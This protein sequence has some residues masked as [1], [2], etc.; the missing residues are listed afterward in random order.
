[1]TDIKLWKIILAGEKLIF[2]Q[3][4]ARVASK[5]EFGAGE[6]REVSCEAQ[7]G[8]SRV[9]RKLFGSCRNNMGDVRTL[10]MKEAHA[11]KYSVRPG[12]NEVVARHGVNVSTIPDRDG[13][14][15][16]VSERD[17]EVVRNT[18]RYEY[19]LPSINWWSDCYVGNRTLV[20]VSKVIS[21][22]IPIVKVSWNS[23]RNFELTWAWEDYLKDK[24]R[25]N[26]D[27]AWLGLTNEEKRWW[28]TNWWPSMRKDIAGR[29]NEAVAR[30]GVHVSTIP[31]R[32]GMY[33]KV[34][35]KDVE[36]VRNT[37]RYEYYLPSIN[38]WSE[39]FARIIEEFGFALRRDSCVDSKISFYL[40]FTDILDTYWYFR[41]GLVLY[42]FRS[43]VRLAYFV[44]SKGALDLCSLVI[45][46]VYKKVKGGA[47]VAFKDE[48]KAAEE[49]E[50]LCEPLKGRSR[51]K[52]KLF[53]S[54]RNKIGMANIVVDAWRRKGGVK[55][56][57]VRD[58][59]RTIQAE[60]SETMLVSLDS[61]SRQSKDF[62]YRGGACDEAKIGESKMIGLEMEQETTKV[63]VIKERLKEAKDRQEG[64][65]LRTAW[66]IVV[67]HE[68]EKTAWPIMVRHVRM[69]EL[70]V[71]YKAEKVCHEEI[72][73][74][75]LVLKYKERHRLRRPVSFGA[76][77]DERVVGI[78][79]SVAWSFRICMDYRKLSEIAI[80]NRCHQMR[81]H[82]EEIPKTDFKMRYGHFEF[83]VIPFGLTK[84]P[85]VF[86]ELMSQVCMT[87]YRQVV[88]VFIDDIWV[89][90]ESK[91]EHESHLKMNLKVLKKDNCYV[92]PNKRRWMK[93]FS[94]YACETKYH[95]GKANIVVDAWRWKGRVKPRRVRDI[96][97]VRTSIM[98]EAHA[99][100]YSVLPR[101]AW[102]IVV[103]H[104][105]EKTVWP[106]VVRHAY[107][108]MAWPSVRPEWT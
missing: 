41:C 87:V 108:K 13:M 58:R 93:L 50:V 6:E 43:A 23:K 85:A 48:F 36:V 49:R 95:M 68:S 34:S 33:I 31:D 15:I 74:K 71:K 101:T 76:Y 16:E 7:Q 5:D 102:P 70:V 78:I 2:V 88:T 64:V 18:S 47:R 35:E 94:D 26:R 39:L 3:G 79:A 32:D 104:E 67:R 80:R 22:K 8:Q 86:I 60:I 10:I 45:V 24:E 107:V 25:V 77:G 96:C 81:V 89:Y 73:K 91:E 63:V 12:V 9:K 1:M 69:R 20:W 14:Y 97:D 72:V 53:R 55:P 28:Y 4:G 19:C 66:P 30:H 51:V 46:M 29:V 84:A 40:S 100:K 21:S 44:K 59:C 56:R 92:K 83:T 52:R 42:A 11:I 82:E 103:R 17:V 105:S 65:K 27:V 75:P 57:R 61:I 99:T 54:F 38:W 106:I 62:D 90:M 98:K 37:S